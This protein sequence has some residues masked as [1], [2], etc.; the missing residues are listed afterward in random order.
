MLEKANSSFVTL[1]F[2]MK[3]FLD[4]RNYLEPNVSR[5]FLVYF[6]CYLQALIQRSYF[7]MP[8]LKIH[9]I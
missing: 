5:D 3:I 2:I 4:F 1:I 7:K 8:L 9:C 6:L